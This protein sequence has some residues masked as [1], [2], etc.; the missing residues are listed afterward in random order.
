M[1]PVL[2]MEIRANAV[3]ECRGNWFRSRLSTILESYT[4]KEPTV[5]LTPIATSIRSNHDV[6]WIPTSTKALAYIYYLTNYATKADVSPQQMLVKARL[7]AESRQN[8]TSAIDDTDCQ[9]CKFLLRLYNSLAHDQEISGVQIAS[10]L[11]Q[12][13]GHYASYS[14]FAHVHLSRLSLKISLS[15]SFATLYHFKRWIGR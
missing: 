3:L 5:G 13:P 2:S 9:D 1:P 7:L 4:F 14:K 8:L 12:F 11:L 10:S 6:S 15:C